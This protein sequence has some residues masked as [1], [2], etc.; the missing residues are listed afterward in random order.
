MTSTRLPGK[1]MLPLCGAP[2]VQRVIERAKRIAGIAGVCLAIPPGD[3]HAP[4]RDV[5]KGQGASIVVGPEED[6]L[7]RYVAAADASGADIVIRVTSDCPFI[8]PAVSGSVLSL[9]RESGAGY[10]RTAIESGYPLGLDTEAIDA[11]LL[12]LAL[13]ESADPFER[14]HVT[15][16]IW[17]RPERFPFVML[18]RVP[19]RRAW[20]LTVD[21]AEDYELAKAVYDELHPRDAEFGFAAMERLLTERPQLLKINSSV[22]HTAAV[23]WQG[24]RRADA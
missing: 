19:D 20:R 10:A 5:A 23:G 11:E 21:T 24:K 8:D 6:V 17:R 12:R 9:L 15:P 7:A 18:D 3:E 4:L 2:L 16:F 1:V 13:R 14:E 22:E